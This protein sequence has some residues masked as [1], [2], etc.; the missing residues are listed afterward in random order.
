MDLE[1]NVLQTLSGVTGYKKTG[2]DSFTFYNADKKAVAVVKKRCGVMKPSELAGEWLI[3]S[4]EGVG[5]KSEMDT[6]PFM[7]FDLEESRVNGNAGCNLFNS[8]ITLEEGQSI[9]FSLGASTMMSCPDMELEQMVLGALGK[10]RKYGRM[11][12]GNLGL[13]DHSGNVCIELKKK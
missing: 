10:I 1:N 3:I 5:A 9:A 4:V 11:S 6:A 12:N 7:V 2:N 13:F 8:A